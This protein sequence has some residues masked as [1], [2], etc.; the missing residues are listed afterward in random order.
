MFHFSRIV[1]G[2]KYVR[3]V[4]H[5]RGNFRRTLSALSR[6]ENK[7]QTSKQYIIAHENK[8]LTCLSNHNV[9]HQ[10][11]NLRHHSTTRILYS[12]QK[13]GIEYRGQVFADSKAKQKFI[14]ERKEARRLQQ[15][16]QQE[17]KAQA[18]K[19]GSMA[20]SQVTHEAVSSL[21]G[22]GRPLDKYR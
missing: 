10:L 20:L 4:L 13:T 16:A 18:T 1:C 9:K 2:S 22:F 12:Q 15:L 19:V 3:M 8:C 6:S 7:C 5:S 17:A 11:S 21:A 14:K